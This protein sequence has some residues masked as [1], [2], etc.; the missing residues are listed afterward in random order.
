MINPLKGCE[1]IRQKQEY[2]LSIKTGPGPENNV[3]IR[4]R[5]NLHDQSAEKLRRNKTET[6]I[7]P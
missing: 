2:S 6:G 7:F 4:K 5:V 3:L 1:G